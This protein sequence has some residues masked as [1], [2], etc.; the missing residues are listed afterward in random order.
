MN[1]K[2]ESFLSYNIDDIDRNRYMEIDANLGSLETLKIIFSDSQ[3]TQEEN[4]NISKR[5][6][7]DRKK[8]ILEL[9]NWWTNQIVKNLIITYEDNPL[10]M[11]F[12]GKKITYTHPIL[13]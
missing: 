13:I 12:P 2:K 4:D 3:F 10:I 7:E 11:D 6:M 1:N 9:Q 5:M 8:Y